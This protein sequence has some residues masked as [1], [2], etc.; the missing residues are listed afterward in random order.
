MKTFNCS[1][2]QYIEADSEEE[3]IEIFCDRVE[4]LKLSIK[5][6]DCFEHHVLEDEEKDM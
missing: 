4:L 1:I 5:D 2:N 3:A 6:V